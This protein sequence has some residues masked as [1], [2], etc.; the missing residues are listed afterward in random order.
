MKATVDIIEP[1]AFGE[2]LVTRALTAILHR[3]QLVKLW[4]F[5]GGRKEE[6]RSLEKVLEGVTSFVPRAALCSLKGRARTE[7][8]LDSEHEVDV[9][10]VHPDGP[11]VPIEVKLALPSQLNCQTS[12]SEPIFAGVRDAAA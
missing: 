10:A 8:E 9:L 4:A 6:R 3:Q 1:H 7:V 2:L 11:S 5:R 12:P